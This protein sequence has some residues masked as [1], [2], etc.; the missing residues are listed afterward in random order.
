MT[1]AASRLEFRRLAATDVTHR[2]V[3][4]LN[5]PE[6][7]RFLETRFSAQDIDSC[8]EYVERMNADPSSHF[9]GV[10]L[11][12]DGRH[13]GNAKLG[14]INRW[15]KTAELSLLL[16]DKAEWGKGYGTEVVRALTAYGFDQLALE[17]IEAG[18]YEANLGS[19][20]AFLRVGY[21]VEGF[22][23]KSLSHGADRCGCFWLGILKHEFRE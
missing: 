16:G 5:D 3:D 20:R 18:C 17:R 13:I 15:H 22:F 21:T 2:Y 10:F 4:W 23:R 7:N 12:D 9:F 1:P 11:K 19:L 14:F 8:I 6:I